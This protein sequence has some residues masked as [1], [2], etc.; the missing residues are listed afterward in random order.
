MAK[1][2]ESKRYNKAVLLLVSAI[3]LTLWVMIN[4]ESYLTGAIM[5][6][7]VGA[8]CIFLYLNWSKIKALR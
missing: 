8:V 1:D 5:Y 3:F 6:I 2:T 4:A 7:I